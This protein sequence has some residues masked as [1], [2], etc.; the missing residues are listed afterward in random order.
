MKKIAALA[1]IGIIGYALY[2]YYKKQIAFLEDLTYQV[3]GVSPR[4]ISK[5]NVSVDVTVK[6][7]NASNVN[8]TITQIILDVLAN[9][10]KVG[11]V[12]ETK[13]ITLLPG[14]TTVLSFNFSFNPQLVLKNLVDLVTLTVA[15]KDLKIRLEGY[16]RARSSFLSTSLPF[17][18]ETSLKEAIKR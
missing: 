13:D 15:A 9:G 11:S 1:G 17:T 4:E 16:I 3:V 6:V 18:Y 5:S 2:R 8:V 14:K 10:V 12:N 7:F